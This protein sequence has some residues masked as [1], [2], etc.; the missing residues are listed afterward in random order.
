MLLQTVMLIM[1][2]NMG[3]LQLR[4]RGGLRHMASGIGNSESRRDRPRLDQRQITFDMLL[5]SPVP[6]FVAQIIKRSLQTTLLWVCFEELAPRLS[7]L[8]LRATAAA[9]GGSGS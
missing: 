6:L 4:I 3:L 8:Q 1:L 7:S 9:Q 2:A 5:A